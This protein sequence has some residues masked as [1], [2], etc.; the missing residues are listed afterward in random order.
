MAAKGS[1]GYDVRVKVAIKNPVLKFLTFQTWRTVLLTILQNRTLH[2]RRRLKLGGSAK[3]GRNREFQAILL[4]RGKILNVEQ[5]WMN[6][7]ERVAVFSAM[8]TGFGAN[9][10]FQRAR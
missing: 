3:S 9:L 1:C 10:M 2:R 6:S 8:G 7:I 4:I 5:V